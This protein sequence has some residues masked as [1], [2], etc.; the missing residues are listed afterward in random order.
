LNDS[1]ILKGIF[2]IFTI[3]ALILYMNYKVRP[4]AATLP[5][6]FLAGLVI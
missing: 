2:E 1:I 5:A 4:P 3:R 6:F